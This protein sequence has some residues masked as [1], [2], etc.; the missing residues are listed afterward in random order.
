MGKNWRGG[1]GRGGSGRGGGGSNDLVSCRGHSIIVGT[2]DTVREREATKELIYLLEQAVEV[3]YGVEKEASADEKCDDE[4]DENGG[5][6][7]GGSSIQDMLKKELSDLKSK[8]KNR[9]HHTSPIKIDTKGLVV[10]R[11]NNKKHCAVAL[12]KSIFDKVKRDG[13]ACSRYLIRLVPLQYTFHCNVQE[14]AAHALK[15][16]KLWVYP[17]S[18]VGSE[19]NRKRKFNLI[20]DSVDAHASNLEDGDNNL[21]TQLQSDAA[22]VSSSTSAEVLGSSESAGM[23][24]TVVS[25]ETSAAAPLRPPFVLPEGMPT[26]TYGVLYKARNHNVVNRGDVIDAVC[27]IMPDCTRAN[28]RN[29]QVSRR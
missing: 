23:D 19:E 15:A 2:S 26:V 11:L 10:V 16:F 28:Y 24:A 5:S 8:S 12:L 1:A 3:V 20:A 14:I 22:V 17:G 9:L 25:P 7:A 18:E 29:P 27:R 21:S 13:L 6:G 4:D